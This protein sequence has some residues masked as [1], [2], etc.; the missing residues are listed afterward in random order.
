MRNTYKHILQSVN[1]V[2]A[3][4][5]A[6]LG[7]TGCAQQKSAVKQRNTEST[8]TVDSTIEAV[9]VGQDQLIMCM[10]GVPRAQYVVHGIVEDENGTPL[11]KK[12]I[13]LQAGYDQIHLQTDENG[14]FDINFDGFP[15]EEMSFEIDDKQY[16]EPI[17]YDGEPIDTW[18]R[19]K[20]TM[21]VKII[22]TRN[23][24]TS[25]P[26]P[27]IMVKYGVPPTRQIQ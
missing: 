26:A 27:A 5:I 17:T 21:Q 20:A 15:L 2:L 7:V 4:L 14:T 8:D 1:T 25:M 18:N 13:L 23:Q 6:A 19:G 9:Q 16:T 11:P 22:H 3:S 12:D 10:Y 24:E